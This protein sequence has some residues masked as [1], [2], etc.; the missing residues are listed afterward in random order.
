MPTS[1]LRR[2]TLLLAALALL[3]PLL[4]AFDTGPTALTQEQA[5]ER[6]DELAAED[7]PGDGVV[8]AG[9]LGFVFPGNYYTPAAVVTKG[10]KLTLYHVDAA[11]HDVVSVAVDE[12]D[13]PLFR[14]DLIGLG[15]TDDVDGVPDLAS[16]TYGFYCTLHPWMQGTL[17][18][19]PD[20][21]ESQPVPPPSAGE[22]GWPV[23]GGDLANSRSAQTGPSSSEV[24]GLEQAWQFES[25]EGDFAGTPVVGQ[26]RVYM[27]SSLGRVVA[28]DRET[29]EQVWKVDLNTDDET[30]LI[31]A[32]AAFADGEVYVPVSAR[33]GA[34]YT[35]YVVALDA[36]T[37]EELWRTYVDTEQ[38]L[39]DL[40][41][42][43]TVWK[44]TVATEN[45]LQDFERL[46]IGLSSWDS[47]GSGAQELH[48]GTVVS[49]D[50]ADQGE[51]VWRTYMYEGGPHTKSE[52]PVDEETGQQYNGAAVWSTPTVDTETGTVYVG[53]GNG[54]TTS[55]EFID[56]L[57]A[58][59]AFSG[60]VVGHYGTVET[61]AW[62][63]TDPYS[64]VDA[65]FGSSPQLVEGPNGEKWLGAGQKNNHVVEET[66]G[67]NTA[68][69]MVG[70]ARYHMIDRETM[71]PVW[72]TT[73]GPGYWLGGFLG[74]TAHDGDKIYGG[75]VFGEQVALNEADGSIAWI[76]PIGDL[77][78]LHHAPTTVAN[79]VVYS[80]DSRG[81]VQAWDAGTGVPLW[82]ASLGTGPSAGGVAVVDG[83]LYVARGLTSS[84]GSITAF[85]L[86]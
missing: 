85:R 68:N 4:V 63:L 20:G 23:Y 11:L 52:I 41:G 24:T 6:A 5:E 65:D 8:V 37:G 18:V 19:A 35:P 3:L 10:S 45:G 49:L 44:G 72:V 32:S 50:L 34:D 67:D 21:S 46:F 48:L 78:G 17:V 51:L 38:P 82:A 62:Q 56:S 76:T 28:L 27:G 77:P 57:V 22:E 75:T 42:S 15:Q 31:T 13:D 70:E 43:P 54:Y 7:D 47:G 71:E 69:A 26:G 12:N 59:D 73:V 61:D 81:L 2:S 25:D 14:S 84:S 36:A 74:S 40:Y 33:Q 39:G 53:T 9:P 1:N 86:P 30:A 79:G 58:L 64:G 16:G 55:H 80:A 29:G 83:T 66:T 60:D